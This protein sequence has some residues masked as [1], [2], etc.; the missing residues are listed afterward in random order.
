MVVG[1]SNAQQLIDL[2]K[3]KKKKK[4]RGSVVVGPLKRHAIVYVQSTS[5]VLVLVVK[6][7]AWLKRVFM[8]ETVNKPS[9]DK[10]YMNPYEFDGVFKAEVVYFLF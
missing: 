7:A 5:Y 9:M 3:R 1:H 6:R 10:L 4:S 2:Q 8:N